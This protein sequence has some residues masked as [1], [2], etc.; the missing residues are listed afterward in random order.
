MLVSLGVPATPKEYG[1]FEMFKV[2]DVDP[3]GCPISILFA[4]VVLL[5]IGQSAC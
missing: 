4:P 2:I 3:S 1:I 5:D